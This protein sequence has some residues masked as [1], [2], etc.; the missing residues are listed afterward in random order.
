MS[1]DCLDDETLARILQDEENEQ[2]NKRR[3][4]CE[5]DERL[6]RS[7]DRDQNEI[8]S[9]IFPDVHTLFTAYNP[10]YF[11]DKLGVVELK[12]SKR[13]TLCAGICCYRLNG[14]CTI[15]LS[16]PLLKLRSS[17]DLVDVLL[18]EMIH[19]YLFITKGHSSHDGHGPEFL[20]IANRINKDAN[21]NITVY[22]NF[23]DEV[24][25]YRQ[26]RW[27]CN[28]RPLPRSGALLWYC[29]KV[30]EQPADRWF[31][32]H[33]RTCGGTFTK[34]AEP[35]QKVKPAQKPKIKPSGQNLITDYV[36]A[37]LQSSSKVSLIRQ[38]T[39]KR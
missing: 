4:I 28:A 22:H 32:E 34:I 10:L 38:P 27:Q 16:E 15:K 14:E 18:H 11:E 6:A 8:T 23:H 1:I 26:H 29:G 36:S 25:Y 33:Q 30:N 12:W 39:K 9:E 20:E 5:D 17:Q 21:T 7:I 24:S 35:A 3:K 31:P 13:L 2:A 19:A 37:P